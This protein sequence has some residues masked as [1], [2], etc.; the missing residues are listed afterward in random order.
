MLQSFFS[1][2]GMGVSR[3]WNAEGPGFSSDTFS[4]AEKVSKK[5]R[6]ILGYLKSKKSLARIAQAVSDCIGIL[7]GR[8]PL[9]NSKDSRIYYVSQNRPVYSLKFIYVTC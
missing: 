5:A 1:L 7:C 6:L 3:K 9:A 2:L 4:I 8:F